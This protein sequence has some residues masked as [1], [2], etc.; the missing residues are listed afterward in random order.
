MQVE[1]EWQV[2]FKSC[3][4]SPG[5]GDHWRNAQVS[6]G[7]YQEEDLGKGVKMT[8]HTEGRSG[9]QERESQGKTRLGFLNN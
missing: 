3:Y 8:T 6:M 7:G 4:I 9:S 5:T 2:R 1:R